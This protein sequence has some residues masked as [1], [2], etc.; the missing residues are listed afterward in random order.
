MAEAPPIIA[1]ERLVKTYGAADTAVRALRE[2]SFTVRAGE[3]VAV[4]GASGSGKSTLLNI[5]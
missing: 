1:V 4:M 2:V 3:F 5:L